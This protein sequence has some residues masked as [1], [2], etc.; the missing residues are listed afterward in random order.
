MLLT[1]CALG[2]YVMWQI[3]FRQPA[4]RWRLRWLAL[5]GGFVILHVAGIWLGCFDF[6]SRLGR[7]DVG[8]PL[9]RRHAVVFS[10]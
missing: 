7:T 6:Y 2:V 4:K 5:D 1:Q 3:D 8:Y 10:A 9:Y